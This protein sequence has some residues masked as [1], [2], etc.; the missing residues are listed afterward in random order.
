M[1]L[2]KFSKLSAEN[3]YNG[4]PDIAL[5][6]YAFQRVDCQLVSPIA[7]NSKVLTARDHEYACE[8]HVFSDILCY[9]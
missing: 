3:V 9:I 4:N 8:V 2:E 5:P 6:L 7:Y 1:G